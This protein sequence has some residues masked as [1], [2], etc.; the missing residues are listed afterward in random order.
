MH[1]R[2][3]S[4]WHSPGAQAQFYDRVLCDPV[5]RRYPPPAD[6]TRRLVKALV[7][8]CDTGHV[9]L[10]EPLLAMLFDNK[11][12]LSSSGFTEMGPAG[13]TLGSA[14]SAGVG[15]RTYTFGS[16]E[17]GAEVGTVVALRCSTESFGGGAETSTV[18]WPAGRHLA[19][20]FCSR[21]SLLKGRR[22][23]ELGCGC[24]TVGL[25]VAKACSPS[26]VLLTDNQPAAILN[27]QHNI[28]VNELTSDG[29]PAVV[30][31]SCDWA[32]VAV[33]MTT[34]SS[35]SSLRLVDTIIA[36]DVT[37]DP[38]VCK[39]LAGAIRG[40]LT[41]PENELRESDGCDGCA[42]AAAAP[43]PPLRLCWVAAQERNPVTWAAFCEEFKR[44]KDDHDRSAG[45]SADALETLWLE[46]VH[47]ESEPERPD[48]LIFGGT[49]TE[50]AEGKLRI[51]RIGTWA[52][53]H[54]TVVD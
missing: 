9:A 8:A 54:P 39:I 17:V 11:T 21:P 12:S 23:V 48:G 46:E 7:G 27:A 32:E 37:Y 6:Y 31:E 28:D 45:G 38:D 24:G 25:A 22:V 10:H 53:L 49:K 34:T 18:V 51:V 16:S 47:V 2:L 44:V 5:V 19:N 14:G 1:T 13:D 35:S 4:D 30:V 52:S 20:Y 40:L 33:D 43:P 3:H 36:A 29:L 26:S 50:A 15:Y 41:R 42:A